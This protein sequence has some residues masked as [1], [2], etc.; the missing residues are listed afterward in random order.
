LYSDSEHNSS[1]L[2][3]NNIPT[4]FFFR[5]AISLLYLANDILNEVGIEFY[6]VILIP[7]YC[8]LIRMVGI[9]MISGKMQ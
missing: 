7:I 3:C 9:I 2:I 8:Y 5:L 4:Q 1:N 6:L